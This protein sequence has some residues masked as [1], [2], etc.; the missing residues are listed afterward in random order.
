MNLIGQIWTWI[1]DYSGILQILLTIAGFLAIT[2]NQLRRE[3]FD[4]RLNNMKKTID[5]IA[6]DRNL[7]MEN[8]LALYKDQY[9]GK[10]GCREFTEDG[11]HL[12]FRDGWVNCKDEN[13]NFFH[14]SAFKPAITRRYAD[15]QENIPYNPRL[16]DRT[17]SYADNCKFHLGKN[18][19]NAPLY[20]LDTVE[21]A[22][23]KMP[24]ITVAEGHYFDFYNTCE[25]VSFEMAYVRRILGKKERNPRTLPVR[26]RQ[27]DLFDTTNR[28]PGIGINTLTILKNVVDDVDE[29][30]HG[31][32]RSFFLLHKRGV[33]VAEGMGNY[34]VVPAGSYQPLQ[35]YYDR[36]ETD[37]DAEAET[38]KNTVLREFGEELLDYEEFLDL[39]T[40]DLLQRLHEI[41][42]PL[43]LGLGFE[44]LNTKTEVLSALVID[45]EQDD[46]ASLFGH[47]TKRSE[48]ENLFGKNENYE[49][50]I[51]L[52]P[53][54]TAM[55]QQYENDSRSTASMKEMMRILAKKEN[56]AIFQIEESAQFQY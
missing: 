8:A 10:E 34:H 31:R 40:S 18:L 14:L 3:K 4:E 17:E 7:F 56:R 48:F 16:P 41:L 53:L 23:K 43:F 9:R 25:Y 33:K 32:K 36:E 12:V 6:A 19:F 29:A 35:E 49:G 2:R 30:E 20:A 51:M 39:N 47:R 24:K 22:P 26:F 11:G 21:T 28:F 52:R 5:A 37:S 44:P 54:T 55:L 13:G 45:V 15:T 46:D 42:H 1:N 38:M 27:K 50:D